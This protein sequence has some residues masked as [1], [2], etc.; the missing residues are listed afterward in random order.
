MVVLVVVRFAFAI[1]ASIYME[2]LRI[3]KIKIM[4]K[5]F[6]M[7]VIVVMVVVVVIVVVISKKFNQETS[8]SV[9]SYFLK[10]L[11]ANLYFF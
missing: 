7:V 3:A 5:A 10:V 1:L 11:K 2:S 4:A 8:R 9:N 6:F